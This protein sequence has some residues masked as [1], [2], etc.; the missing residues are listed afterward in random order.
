MI[1]GLL[2]AGCA[3]EVTSPH[4]NFALPGASYIDEPV[5]L[6]SSDGVGPSDQTGD[7]YTFDL[8]HVP[9]VADSTYDELVVSYGTGTS[10]DEDVWVF[11]GTT[12]RWDQVG[13]SVS[14]MVCL[15]AFSSHS[16]WL[17]EAGCNCKEHVSESRQVRVRCGSRPCLGA[18]RLNPDYSALPLPWRGDAGALATGLACDGRSLW[19]S[20][21]GYDGQRTFSRIYNISF[22]GEVM[23]ELAAPSVP[24][25]A[26]AAS[27]HALWLF[28]AP[29]SIIRLS[30]DG[31]P[32]GGFR[33]PRCGFGGLAWGS[34]RLWL[35][36]Y[37]GSGRQRQILVIDPDV[38]C[39]AGTAIVADSLSIP[40][41]AYSGMAWTGSH[42]LLVDD[43]LHSISSEGVVTSSWALPVHY[44][45]DIAWDGEAVCIECSG[46]DR[47]ALD[48]RVICRFRLR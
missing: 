34:G 40:E 31:H 3:D 13:Y 19:I 4:R 48:D 14:W 38:S 1:A 35:L 23:E 29:D 37:Q 46:P 6:E 9:M 45:G 44:P 24:V 22:T 20:A 5:I 25:A 43:R 15:Q 41:S 47:C 21:C 36:R 16:H 39:R 30:H 28:V 17:G 32:L 10:C 2:L 7:I 26:M 12:E 18:L 27:R 8:S 42:I 33:S 11:N